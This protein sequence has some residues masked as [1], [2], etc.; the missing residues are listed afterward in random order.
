MKNVNILKR[1][2]SITALNRYLEN[3]KQQDAFFNYSEM[4]GEDFTGTESYSVANDLLLFG[5]RK[6]QKKIEDAGVKKM[7]VEIQK[8]AQRRSFR[9]SV[10]GAVPNVPAYISGAPNSMVTVTQTNNKKRVLT[11]G[12]SMTA[13]GNVDKKDIINAS[14]KIILALMIIEASGVR[15]NLYSIFHATKENHNTGCAIR[16]KTSGQHFDT[17]KMAYP[18]AHSSMLRRQMFKFEEVTEGVPA[19]FSGSYGRPV[20]DNAETKKFCSENGLK[21]DACCTYY[22][23]VNKTPEEIVE[24]IT[25]QTKK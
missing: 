18:L 17:L 1:F 9:S 5:D 21:L 25:A 2:D 23:V 20:A 11:I 7:R 3:G 24:F 6:L 10:V 19:C 8:R 14:A 22:E 12:Y 13:A 16:I 15:T 4:N